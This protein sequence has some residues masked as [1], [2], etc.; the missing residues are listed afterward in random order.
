M[1]MLPLD[2]FRRNNAIVVVD[3]E[4]HR[5]EQPL[6]ADVAEQLLVVFVEGS[7]VQRLPAIE[8]FD[9]TSV[10]R[11]AIG[12]HHLTGEVVKH[13]FDLKGVMS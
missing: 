13:Q 8:A 4:I 10:V 2:I 7:R 5:V 1:R 9:T 6:V 11:F 12:G 3:C